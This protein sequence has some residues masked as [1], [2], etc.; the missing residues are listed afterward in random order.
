M[1]LNRAGGLSSYKESIVLQPLKEAPF[2]SAIRST[3]HRWEIPQPREWEMLFDY[4]N[5]YLEQSRQ[6][7]G[8]CKTGLPGEQVR[9]QDYKVGSILSEPVRS[10][11]Q[12]LLL[13]S[14]LS[15]RSNCTGYSIHYESIQSVCGACCLTLRLR[16]RPRSPKEY[17]S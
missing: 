2:E 1:L 15:K 13:C 8:S 14:A 3:R 11:E 12:E 6:K 10:L 16:T 7:P 17:F 4:E 9:N 5:T